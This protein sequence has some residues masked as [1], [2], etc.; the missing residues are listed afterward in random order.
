MTSFTG[1]QLRMLSVGG[2]QNARLWS[3]RIAHVA[4]YFRGV[5]AADLA[6][7]Y[8]TGTTAHVGESAAA[9][10]SRLASYV[11]L[12]VTTQG[13]TFDPMASQAELGSSAL[14]HMRQIETT[15]SGKL[16]ASRSSA[17]LVFQSRDLRYNPTPAISL[18]YADL[19]TD[20]AEYADDDQKMVN[21]V[22]AS[23]VGGA[24]QRVINQASIDTYGTKPRSMELYKNTDN[25]VADA[26]NWLV[27]RYADPPPEIRQV[28]V[29]AYSLPLTTY[30]A[31]LAADVSTVLELTGLPAQAP[32]S[33][34]TVV[35]EG[36][37]EQIGLGR[38]RIDFHTSRA[39]TDTVW[40]LD[41][42]NYSAL[43][44]TTRLAY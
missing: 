12:T 20:D 2:Y 32:A 15:E 24:T 6:G 43:G 5:T 31:L 1:D 44:S 33:A 34:A 18:P 30:R 42:P 35:I 19:E 36:Y 29:E 41:D 26:A 27:S 25:S 17:A 4:V 23:R 22:T 11:G 9:R 14:T 37:S 40:L 7:H 38:H 16:L 8:A 3:G 21:D 13:T 28:P 10:M 39:D